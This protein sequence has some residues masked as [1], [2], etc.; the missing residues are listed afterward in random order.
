MKGDYLGAFEELV[1]LAVE[2]LGEAAYGANIQRVL[3]REAKRARV[4]RR[5]AHRARTPR[6]QAPVVVRARR[7]HRR[8]RRQT[9]ACVCGDARGPRGSARRPGGPAACRGTEDF[10]KGYVKGYGLTI[11][12]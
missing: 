10:V 8:A 11:R 2:A 9:T 4:S 1:L 6:E 3:E 7:A 12:T 5:R